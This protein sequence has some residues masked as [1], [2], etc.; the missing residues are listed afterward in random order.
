[1]P[2]T[3][4]MRSDRRIFTMPPIFR[5]RC[6]AVGHGCPDEPADERVRRADRQAH[7][8]RDEVPEDGREQRRDQDR[9]GDRHGVHDARAY[10][11]GHGG[12]EEGAGDVHGR[13]KDHRLQGREDLRRDH[14][15]DGVRA[16]VPAVRDIE[17]HGKDDDEDQD[18]MHVSGRCLRGYWRCL[19]PGPRR[20]PG[21]G[22]CPSI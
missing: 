21:S 15:G 14:R 22:R 20:L 16:V 7:E 13:R 5:M 18:I 12:G 2:S 19:P 10:G 9:V 1:M 17:E 3:G 8:D 11:L 4:E 6:A